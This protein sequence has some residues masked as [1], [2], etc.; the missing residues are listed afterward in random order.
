MIIFNLSHK[1]AGLSQSGKTRRRTFSSTASSRGC[2]QIHESTQR[3][4]VPGSKA[5][6]SFESAGRTH[7]HLIHKATR[8]QTHRKLIEP[9]FLLS[10]ELCS[11]HIDIQCIALGTTHEIK[12]THL[13]HATR[14]TTVRSTKQRP[15]ISGPNR[16][17]L[18]G[19][20]PQQTLSLVPFPSF[21]AHNR[22]LSY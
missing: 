4:F 11:T 1:R 5:C 14:L 21:E 19:K 3:L 2:T 18:A 6:L 16:C 7:L 12:S 15:I 8:S 13:P 17:V 10:P 20:A 22:C 9:L